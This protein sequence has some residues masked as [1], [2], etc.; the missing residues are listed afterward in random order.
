[1]AAGYH[2]PVRI[3]AL[4][5]DRLDDFLEL[6]YALHG[7]DP[8]WIPPLR[9]AV[10]REVDGSSAFFRYGRLQAYLAEVDGRVVGRAAASINPRMT[11]PDGGPVGQI[12]YFESTE[13]P[14]VAGGLFAAAEAWL[15]EGGCRR[16]VGPMNGGIH[17]AHRLLVRG[18]ERTPF[19]LEPRNPTYYP[20]LFEAHGYAVSA[21]WYSYDVTRA[22]LEPV[23]AR[24]GRLCRSSRFRMQ[25]LELSPASVAHV[26]SLF[27][28]VWA[29]HIGYAP[30][31]LEELLESVGALLPVMRMGEL[32]TLVDPA[33]IE[34]G[35]GFAY[36]DW[37]AEV[38][39]L[40][41]DAGGWAR[42]LGT[43]YPPRLIL[44]TVAMTPEVRGSRGSLV[45]L[46]RGIEL[47]L[48]DPTTTEG[49][50]ALSLD[51]SMPRLFAATREY[52][53]YEK[54]LQGGY[55]ASA[56]QRKPVE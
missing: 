46:A 25:D 13:D 16:V 28:R 11:D 31:E 48:R 15:R 14:A 36:P 39:A 29:G 7:R 52:A 5:P 42:W 9:A 20:A 18:F 17:R 19:L 47:V 33:G 49:V 2:A 45:V 23:A 3:V 40:A 8:L 50:W 26:H 27:D 43:P 1:M 38:R 34:V 37:A 54:S 51:P 22:Q 56:Q 44:H 30:M 32:T 12:G 41:G 53:L 24:L 10:R 6:P 35:I 55:G 21:R 4:G